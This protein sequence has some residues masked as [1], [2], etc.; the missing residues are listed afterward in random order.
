[1]RTLPSH[2]ATRK[3]YANRPSHI[4]SLVVLCEG[5]VHMIFSWSPRVRIVSVPLEND[6]KHVHLHKLHFQS[7]RTRVFS[8]SARSPEELF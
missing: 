1:M 7:F 4:A 2:I 3:L 6:G 5:R 8:A